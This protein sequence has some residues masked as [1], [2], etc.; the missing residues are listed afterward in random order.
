MQLHTKRRNKVEQQC[1]N[2]LVYIKYNRALRRQYDARDTID[3]IALDEI[4]Y[5]NEW[6]QGRLNTNSDD[7]EKNARVFEDDDLTWGDVARAAGV[8]ED[9][10]AF[11]P[12]SSKNIT[13]KASSSKGCSSKATKKAS[14]CSSKSTK[15]RLHLVNEV[16]KE[17]NFDDTDEEDFN[18]YISNSEREDKNDD[19]D[20]DVSL[21]MN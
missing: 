7:D 15:I 6:M 8:D 9:T 21:E 5:C 10:Y 18:C 20:E 1:L 11:R 12:R 3:P 13:S 4:D 14:T 17:V 16:E 19:N 2:D